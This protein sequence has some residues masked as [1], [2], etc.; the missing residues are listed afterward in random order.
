M[1]IY[2][3]KT[4]NGDIIDSSEV[5]AAYYYYTMR[6][7]YLGWSD[8]RFMEKLRNRPKPKYNKQGSARP[9]TQKERKDILDA[10]QKEIEF[11]IANPDKT[12]P[13][14]RDK[15]DM[16]GNVLTDPQILGALN[17]YG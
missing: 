14:R 1:K 17:K 9:F 6:Y 4:P 7:S 15:F 3:F 13:G 11:A 8:G 10:E 12:P 5:T 2:Y 16:A